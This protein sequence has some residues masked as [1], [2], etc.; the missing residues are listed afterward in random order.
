MFPLFPPYFFPRQFFTRA[1]IFR[2]LPTIWTP[3]TVLKSDPLRRS[4]LRPKTCRPDEAPR[5]TWE[6]IS[7][8]QGTS[9]SDRWLQN[10]GARMIFHR[11]PL[12]ENQSW[13]N[14]VWKKQWY[15]FHLA[16]KVNFITLLLTPF[17]FKP[18]IWQE[19]YKYNKTYGKK[20]E[21]F[22]SRKR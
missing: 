9:A 1:L 12:D 13:E 7:G 8:T 19:S 22:A 20:S 2:P 5:R 6:K 4:F 3:R 18:R 21:S 10:W 17:G 16:L 15:I 11:K 14:S